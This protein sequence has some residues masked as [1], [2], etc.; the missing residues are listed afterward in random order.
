MTRRRTSGLFLE[1]KLKCQSA[2]PLGPLQSGGEERTMAVGQ[3]SS[4]AALSS[5]TWQHTQRQAGPDRT[6]SHCGMTWMRGI[7]KWGFYH[8][9][10]VL[11]K[12]I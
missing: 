12:S 7:A 2:E 6:A 11:E 8:Q 10:P 3:G 9:G 1:G 5:V 4:V